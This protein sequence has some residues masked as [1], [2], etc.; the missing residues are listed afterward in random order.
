MKYAID[1]MKNAL[2]SILGDNVVSIYLYGSVAMDDFKL[3]WSDIDIIC[4][5]KHIMSEE[6]AEELVEL[7]QNLLKLDQ[8]N[9]YFRSFEGAI[10]SL[11]E[12]Y[13]EEYT[14][15]VYWGTSGQRITNNYVFDVFSRY[16]LMNDGILLYGNDIRQSLC[17]PTYLQ[18]REGVMQHLETIRK[19]AITTNQSLYSCGWLL[20][21]ARC[22]YTL[23]TGQVISKTM[24]GYWA[25]EQELCPVEED[26]RKTIMIRNEP[27]K[28]KNMPEVVSWL[29]LL[30]ESVQVFANVLEIE[31]EQTK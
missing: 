23:R 27:M 12:F 5:I 21:T 18:L 29:S 7:R 3:G 13:N 20:D 25:L 30:G 16:E 22:L 14:R 4:F 15:V 6:Q 31:L 17:L 11:E 1:T 2:V 24:A 10:V 26:L 8:N 19:H 28:Y 9:T